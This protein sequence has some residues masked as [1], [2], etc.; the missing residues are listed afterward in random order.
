[1]IDYSRSVITVALGVWKAD[2]NAQFEAGQFVKLNAAGEVTNIT[3]E[4]DTPFGI[5]K[6]NKHQVLTTAV[7]GEQV[8]LYTDEDAL[9][10]YG[11]IVSGTE[12]VTNLT[13]TT[14]YEK[15]VDYT[16]NYTNGAMRRIDGGG[17]AEGQ[18]V[19]V[20]Y[21]RNLTGND[22]DLLYGRNFMNLVD[23]TVGPG[24][25]TVIQDFAI[26]YTDQYDTT[27]AYVPGDVLRLTADGKVTNAGNGTV[28][29]VCVKS[30]TPEDPYLGIKIG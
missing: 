28:V 20:N 27:K 12:R 7:V 26:V 18:T 9:L 2:P 30:P 21:T 29:G 14:V 4:N 13:G 6:W 19:V 22:Y 15:D 11:S 24:M 8:A 16:I 25:I 23:D 10:K 5:A 3:S 1:M 17:I